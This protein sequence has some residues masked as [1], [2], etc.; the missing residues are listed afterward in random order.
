M[1][2]N[3]APLPLTRSTRRRFRLLSILLTVSVVLSTLGGSSAAAQVVDPCLAP[4]NAI[5][6]ENCLAGSPAS[7][8][9]ISFA[10]D[11]TI[12]G[13]TTDISANKG[14]TVRFKIQSDAAAYRLDVYRMGY[15]GGLGARKVATVQ[16]SV[17]LPQAQPA[18]LTD[19]T[20]GLVDCGNWAE[21]AAW[22]VPSNAT[23]GIYFA[24]L[25][26]EDTGGASHV[27]FVV[28]DDAGDSDLLFQTSDT[29]WQAYNDYGGNSLYSNALGNLPGLRAS[30]VSYNRPIVVRAGNNQKSF[31]RNSEYPMVRWLEANGYDVS[32]LSGVDS[33]RLGAA[34]LQRHKAFL[35]VGHDEY[36]SG[37]QRANVE[38]AREAGVHLAFFSGNEVYWKTRWE[39]SIDGHEKPYRTLVSYKETFAGVK[40][41]PSP[42]WTGT[43]RDVRAFNPDGGRPENGLTGTLFTVQN[44]SGGIKVPAEMGKLRLWR[45]TAVAALPAGQVA[46]LGVDI[47]GTEWNEDLDNGFRPAGLA[48]LSSSTYDVT[49]RM[50]DGG[51]G[52]ESEFGPG[53]ATHNLTL[54]RHLTKNG[55]PSTSGALVFGAG[56]IQYAWGL[57]DIHDRGPSTGAPTSD[58]ALKQATV[59]LFAEMGVQPTTLQPGL[60]PALASTDATAPTSL[61]TGTSGTPRANAA[62]TVTGTA[63]DAGGV[64]A[65]VEVSIDG[66]TWHR[67][68]LTRRGAADPTVDWSYTWTPTAPGTVTVRSRAVDDSANL[69]APGAP[70]AVSVADPAC[71]CTLW[72]GTEVPQSATTN[73]IKPIELGTR[74]QTDAPG[75]ATGLRFYKEPL[76]TGTHIVRLWQVDGTNTGTLLSSVPVVT[77]FGQEGASGWQQVALSAPVPLDP[78]KTYIASV[79]SPTGRYSYDSLY[80]RDAGRSVY[81][82]RALRDSGVNGKSGTGNGV[83]DEGAD[84]FPNTSF[85]AT[86]YWVDVVFAFAASDP[87]G[88]AVVAQSPA[89]NAT[90]VGLGSAIMAAFSEPIDA[91]TLP[92]AFT[93]TLAN[94]FPVPATVAY[95]AINRT[96]TLTPSSPLALGV[97]YKATV[98]GVLDPVGNPMPSPTV[99][100]FSTQGPPPCFSGGRCTLWTDADVPAGVAQNAIK[101]IEL[102]VR[103]QTDVVGQVSALR[104]YKDPNNT[105][106]HIG[107]LWRVDSAT[108]GTLLADGVVF[109]DESGSGWQEAALAEPILLSPNETYIASYV[110]MDGWY[111][112]QQDRFLT[113]H[114]AFPLR[115][116]QSVDGL[117]TGNGIFDEGADAFPVTS[118][119]ATNYGVDVVFAPSATGAAGAVDV[120]IDGAPASA[121][122]GAPISLTAGGSSPDA[123]Y[124]WGVTRNGVPVPVA[125]NTAPSFTF[126][127]ADDGSYVVTLNVAEVDQMPGIAVAAIQVSNAPPTAV[128]SAGAPVD[129]PG[130]V[131]VSFAAAADPSSVDGPFHY[132][133]SCANGDLSGATYVGSGSSPTTSCAFDDSG[134]YTIKGR[135]IDKDGGFGEYTAVATVANVAPTIAGI[136]GA[137]T[138]S[139]PEGDT[140]ALGSIVTDPSGPDAMAGY[141]FVWGVTRDVG[142]GPVPYGAGGASSFAFTP[143]DQGSYAVTIS[144]TDQDGATSQVTRLDVTVANVAPTVEITGVPATSAIGAAV[145]LGSSV[146][147]RSTADTVAGFTYA[148]RVTRDGNPFALDG[149]AAGPTSSFTPSAG[150]TYVVSLSA[151]DKDGAVGNAQATIAVANPVPVPAITGAPTSGPEGTAITLGSTVTGPAAGDTIAYSW[152]VTRNGVPVPVAENTAPSFTFTPADDGSYVVTLTTTTGSGSGQASKTIDVTNVVPV[153]SIAGAPDTSPEGTAIDLTG[154]VVDP[155]T[156]DTITLG[157]TVSRNGAPVGS[158]VSGP[159]LAFTPDENGTYVVTLTATDDEGGSAS[160]SKAIQVFNISPS[161]LNLNPN[162]TAVFENGAVT[163][164]A[165]FVDPGMADTHVVTINWGDGTSSTMNLGAGVLSFTAP[166]H[167]YLDDGPTGTPSDVQSITVTVVDDDGSAG[168]SATTSVT[169]NNVAPTITSIK[170]PIPPQQ[171]GAAITAT[172]ELAD[173]GTKDTHTVV[174]NWDDGTSS[175]HTPTAG[176]VTAT[177]LYAAA[178]VH[179]LVVK[180]TDDDGGVVEQKHPQYVVIYDP[181]AGFVTGG[182]WI[183]SP[184]NAYLPNPSLTGKAVFGFTSKYK[185]G[186]SVPTGNTEFEFLVGDGFAFRST[187]Y[188]WLAVQGAKAQYRG[189]GTINGAGNYEFQITAIDGTRK[190]SGEP[191]RFRIKIWQVVTNANGSTTQVVVYDNRRGLPDDDELPTVIDHGKIKIHD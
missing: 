172:V 156:A 119:R 82:L 35:S 97:T 132:A 103:F 117:G 174:I 118:Y 126:T 121:T 101:P 31:V 60:V 178:G 54:Y 56:T 27:Y 107:R 161:Q 110:S 189:K 1:R 137:P 34:N 64:V 164:N 37:A 25:V 21:S 104:F 109:Y 183:T 8:W 185:K 59:N 184:V 159:S 102:G 125:E 158:P 99:W 22:A 139:V 152:G 76:N 86:N 50:R 6:A 93:L 176:V 77:P 79:V 13:F 175:T 136:T 182:G 51:V 20:T 124:S 41:D 168:V 169:V 148:W 58:P 5:V 94:G 73:E 72:S 63:T 38:A 30:K 179:E 66:V 69:G 151:T 154:A 90:G 89:P 114:L 33:D 62:A 26:R 106:T 10:G 170:G 43:W 120:R 67:A 157:W 47:L 46:T 116:L 53:T 44:T 140:V 138:G 129:E 40:T 167:Q 96:A 3:A 166:P 133:F 19:N 180:V 108:A 171:R 115:A 112:Y 188:D 65:G 149:G 36:W 48:K 57:D 18:C 146:T 191:D 105:G 80:F 55:L 52:R 81:P 61:V 98:D 111:S 4:V 78:A 7:D 87:L 15:Y 142:A 68:G 91:T 100:T 144:A 162:S 45:N 163:L 147:D 113:A 122:E 131:T 177:H 74:F 153:P 49:S 130:S 14:E 190:A 173:V 29:T 16:P 24:R 70:F 32:Y 17:A 75:F 155:G 186:M 83:F 84:A 165:A 92:S 127:P 145:A 11:P 123:A 42:V 128:L 71:P 12:Q 187:S 2:D 9:D 143:N 181:D 28:R 88:P 23:S 150:G 160:Q 134:A 141:S 85:D 39:A 135:V 95:D